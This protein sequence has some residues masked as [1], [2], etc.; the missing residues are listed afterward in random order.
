MG[1]ARRLL[2]FQALEEGNV[3]IL[4]NCSVSSIKEDRVEYLKISEEPPTPECLSGVDTF[5]NAL[6]VRPFDPLSEELK[7]YGGRLE[8][9]GDARSTGTCLQAIAQGAGA[10]LSI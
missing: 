4:T 6:G 3:R 2:L 9:I 10:A 7:D 8:V 1:P 5:V